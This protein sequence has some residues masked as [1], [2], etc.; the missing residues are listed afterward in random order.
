[1]SRLFLRIW[2]S[3]VI[4]LLVAG[5]AAVAIVTS[6]TGAT[7]RANMR[8]ALRGPLDLVSE[9]VGV[10]MAAGMTPGD[11]LA[12][13]TR[14]FELPVE[15]VARGGADLTADELAEIGNE[16]VTVATRAGGVAHIYVPMKSMPDQ[17]LRL[18]P[19]RMA[20][21]A[22]GLPPPV[23]LGIVLLVVFIG[24]FLVVRPIERRLN[25]LSRA[26]ESFGSGQLA[27]R[28]DARGDDALSDLATSFNGM[29]ERIGALVEHQQEL[30]RVV[31]HELRSPLQRVR[32]ALEI[33][34]E[35]G[36]AEERAS[37][38]D[39]V[40]RDVGEL[41]TLVDELLM[42]ARLEHGPA[43][44]AAL[45]DLGPSL[46]D[47]V[48]QV[49]YA[50]PGPRAT[51]VLGGESSPD[52]RPTR[53]PAMVDLRLFR[54]AVSNLIVNAL[55]HARTTVRVRAAAVGGHVTIDVDDDGPGVPPADRARIF[56]PF[57]RGLES[58]DKGAGLGLAI[59]RRI[60]ERHSGKVEVGDAELG[61]A[62]FRLTLP[63]ATA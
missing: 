51:L 33:A 12:K 38:L 31:S 2:A 3:I 48:A 4:A 29:A 42:Y 28:A 45:T 60:A 63:L 59:V 34:R 61:G 17:L 14:G 49:S 21:M 22:R 5:G 46:A 7:V 26:A 9:R 20:R 58:D 23:I 41:E 44:E 1:M 11:A 35:S 47:V 50:T 57:R 18:G 53:L 54:R 52:A 43:I 55:R 62:R 15:M 37:R 19:L 27:A 16:K 39:R 56:E 13:V 25:R 30:L 36:N 6:E 24:V 10:E 8:R 40:D 32:F